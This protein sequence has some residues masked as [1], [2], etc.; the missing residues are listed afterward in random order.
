MKETSLFC[1]DNYSI[2]NAVW[3]TCKNQPCFALSEPPCLF[4]GGRFLEPLSEGLETFCAT[5]FVSLSPVVIFPEC[6][7]I[8]QARQC[9]LGSRAQCLP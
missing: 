9:N 2:Y 5:E 4:L 8:V 1:Y 6:R 3:L 7:Y